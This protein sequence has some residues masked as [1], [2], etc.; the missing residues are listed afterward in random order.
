LDAAANEKGK[1]AGEAKKEEEED[2]GEE[3]DEEGLENKDIEL[4]MAQ[5]WK[6][7]MMQCAD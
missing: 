5:V 4:V 3:V 1:E 7:S 6:L 2:D